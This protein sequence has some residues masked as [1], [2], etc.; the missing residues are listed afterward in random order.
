MSEPRHILVTNDDGIDAPGLWHLA[1]VMAEIGTVLVVAPDKEASGSGTMVT[2]RSDL[3][4]QE[5]PTRIPGVRA[6]QVSGTPADCVLVGLRQLKQ[7]WISL[8]AAGI[9]PGANLA[10]DLFLSGTCGASLIGAFR[11]LTSVA[12]SLDLGLT[13]EGQS[14]PHWETGKS[15][16]RSIAAGIVDGLIPDGAFLN[17]NIPALPVDEV[18]GFAITRPAPGGYVHL[19]EKRDEETGILQRTLVPD[20]RHAHP[21]T[22]IRAVIDGYVSVSPLDTSLA[23][24]EHAKLLAK[25]TDS[26]FSKIHD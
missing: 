10:V 15:V 25:H 14:N 5:V 8:I 2:T 4:V 11:N 9:N 26:L 24:E 22:D 20:T 12:I 1:E 16:A 18:R 21:G 13:E 7:G 6:Y 23:H 17:V 3:H 19:V